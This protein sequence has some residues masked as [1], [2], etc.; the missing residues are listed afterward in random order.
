MIS[1]FDE[2]KESIF[3]EKND[4]SVDRCFEIDRD[5]IVE[6]KEELD[7]Y[8]L[9]DDEE[10]LLEINQSLSNASV[11]NDHFIDRN[12]EI[13]EGNIIKKNTSIEYS[14][15]EEE[16]EQIKEEENTN[17]LHLYH[18]TDK[19]NLESIRK[20][21]LL[22]QQE[23]YERGIQYRSNSNDLSKRLD[24]IENLQ[25]YI[26]LCL[27]KDTPMLYRAIKE[28]RILNPILLEISVRILHDTKDIKISNMNATDR[29]Q[30]KKIEK[31]IQ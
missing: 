31:G 1:Q 4:S 12:E 13:V 18:F 27:V 3:R 22:S 14:P 15:M 11:V 9:Q 20:Y 6:Y 26:R 24:K 16:E 10:Y 30:D 17:Y 2:W 29:S 28:G 5:S 8:F 25:D 7:P 21:G 19:S 23:L